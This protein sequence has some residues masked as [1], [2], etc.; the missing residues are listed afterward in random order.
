MLIANDMKSDIYIDGKHINSQ[1][2]FSHGSTSGYFHWYPG[3]PI[4][5]AD[6]QCLRLTGK[7]TTANQ[8]FLTFN[9][10]CNGKQPYICEIPL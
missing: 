4:S 7:R 8:R 10:F 9:D 6:R 1:W 2:K 3:Y 5:D